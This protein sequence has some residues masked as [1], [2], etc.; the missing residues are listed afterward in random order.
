MMLKLAVLGLL[1]LFQIGTAL[2]FGY[3]PP[4]G[5]SNWSTLFPSWA[6]CSSGVRQS[7]INIRPTE[8]VLWP[9]LSLAIFNGEMQISGT[10]SN[11]EHSV[12]Y[13]ITSSEVNSP[14]FYASYQR[15]N[16]FKDGSYVLQQLHF[17]WGSLDTQGSENQFDGN[18]AVAEVHFV[19]RNRNFTNAEAP[20]Q[21]NGYLVLGF[22]LEVC[23]WSDFDSVFGNNMEN[24][25]QIHVYHDEVPN[26]E[27]RLDD[28]YN[29]IGECTYANTYYT[30]QGSF[31]TPPCT[32]AV[33]W[34][35]SEELLCISQVQLN[36]LRAQNISSTGPLLVNNYR[37]V[38]PLNQRI[39]L[40]N[41]STVSYSIQF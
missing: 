32:E 38:Q 26:I 36:A 7:P 29:C 4:I 6:I 11:N 33:T 41:A 13:T 17:H 39:I 40:T 9:Q 30:F 34:W 15:P 10:L 24:L 5:P 16:N 14:V 2:E 12:I 28:I 31:T 35:V 25:G 8:A 3:T 20:T 22:L 21:A 27:L 37:P 1:S 23:A 19:T 18:S